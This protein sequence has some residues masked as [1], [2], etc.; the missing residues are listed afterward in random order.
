MTYI[1][2]TTPESFFD[3]VRKLEKETLNYDNEKK[4]QSS[5]T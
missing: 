3:T 5:S 1:V 2:L 4:K